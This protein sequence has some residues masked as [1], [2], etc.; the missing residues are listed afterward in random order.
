MA[1]RLRPRKD[2]QTNE[3]VQEVLNLLDQVRNQTL[4]ALRPTRPKETDAT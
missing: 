1:A 4:E 2:S 3:T